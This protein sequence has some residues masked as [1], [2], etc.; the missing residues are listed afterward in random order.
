[1]KITCRGIRNGTHCWCMM[2]QIC[3]SSYYY[4][5]LS[6]NSWDKQ[7]LRIYSYHSVSHWR[8]FLKK[9]IFGI[10]ARS[11]RHIDILGKTGQ[12]WDTLHEYLH[13]F[14]ICRHYHPLKL[15]QSVF[16]DVLYQVRPKKQLS[17][18]YSACSTVT[19]NVEAD[20]SIVSLPSSNISMIVD[21]ASTL[22][23]HIWPEQ[24]HCRICSNTWLALQFVC[25]QVSLLATL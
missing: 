25:H 23:C 6:Q 11:C 19:T 9:F 10:F 13:A 12:K 4:L 24:T 22:Q 3:S 2:L 18:E 21:R 1:M 17:L 14:V 7:L 8:D 16:C 15:R 5:T 20:V